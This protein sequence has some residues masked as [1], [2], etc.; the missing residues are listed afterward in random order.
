MRQRTRKFIGVWLMILLLI[1]YPIAVAVI[2]AEQLMWL[3]VWASLIFFLVAGLFWA[4]PA[5]VIIKW[6]ARPDPE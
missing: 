6:M 5:G 4:V 1:A 3:P 2:Y